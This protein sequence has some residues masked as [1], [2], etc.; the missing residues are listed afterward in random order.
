MP[1]M[2]TTRNWKPAPSNRESWPISSCSIVT[3]SRL[4]QR[5]FIRH[6]CFVHCWRDKPSSTLDVFGT[7]TAM[8]HT[9]T[10]PARRGWS[11]SPS[12]LVLDP[13]G[14]EIASHVDNQLVHHF[15]VRF[16]L[17]PHG[18]RGKPVRDVELADS[19]VRHRAGTPHGP[20]RTGG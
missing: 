6:A 11:S 9:K 3:C 18:Y 10:A 19:A 4:T 1:R 7:D 17:V 12:G 20:A 15:A 8:S 5:R 14:P 16:I 13:G 2:P